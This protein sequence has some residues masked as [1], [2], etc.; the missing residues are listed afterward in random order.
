MKK[1][2]HDPPKTYGAEA[3]NFLEDFYKSCGAETTQQKIAVLQLKV[4]ADSNFYAFGGALTD[5][6]KLG[7]LEYDYLEQSNKITLV[8]A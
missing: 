2:P 1:A 7:C 6:M 4:G 8:L 3:D 5:E